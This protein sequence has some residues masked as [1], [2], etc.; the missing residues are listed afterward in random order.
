[1][2]L[3]CSTYQKYSGT[4][5]IPKIIQDPTSVVPIQIR[6]PANTLFAISP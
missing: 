3:L 4:S 5:V 2:L 1:M 6:D